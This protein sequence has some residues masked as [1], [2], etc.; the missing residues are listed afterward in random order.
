MSDHDTDAQFLRHALA[1]G[2]KGIALTSPNPCV[3]GVV[4]GN[5]VK[6]AGEGFHTYDG[7]R[8]AEI[9]AL[10]QAGEKA[11]GATLYVNLEPCSHVGRTGP[12]A[13]AIIKAKISRVV[14][15]M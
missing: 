8:H 5:E 15:C 7:M 3:V 13:E 2:R 12:C 4:V 9:I 14:A 6:I 11:R 10:E 1:L